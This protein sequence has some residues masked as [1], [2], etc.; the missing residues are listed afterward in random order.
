MERKPEWL[1]VRYNQEAVNEV[2]EMM[3]DLKLTTVCKEANCLNLGECYRKHTATFMI[4]GSICTRN[5]R[6]CNVTHGKPLP[7]DPEEPENVAQAAKKLGLRHVVLTCSTRDDLPD[8]G[9][10][11]FAKT[12]CAIRAQCPGTTVE[13]LTS[14]MRGDHAAFDT[15][16]AVHPDVF[17][18]LLQVLDDGRITDSQGRTVDF[19]NTVIVMTSN[20]GS[21]YILEGIKDGR[22][23]EEARAQ[24]NLLLKQSFRPEFLNRIDDIVFYK[25]LDKEE[26]F[27][28]T[29]LM[30]EDIRK[31]LKERRLDVKLTDR[32]KNY[33]AETG[34]DPQYGAR[35]LK[36][37][38][39]SKLE[40]LLARK[41]IEGDPAP[42]T[43]FPV[44]YDGE[45][46]TVSESKGE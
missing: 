14:D 32:A 45:N 9:A 18:V 20:L 22:I 41:I 36:R 23:T 25:P 11:H 42:D 5:C 37:L 34:Y 40:P 33:L 1:K 4:L 6:F 30:L 16:I 44:D 28:I 38:L 29:D 24:V 2:A 31:R 12:V 46:L 13:T 15:V 26:I 19:K 17:N 7:P 10:E 8:G 39:S 35:P 21:S 43:V 3:R 27:K